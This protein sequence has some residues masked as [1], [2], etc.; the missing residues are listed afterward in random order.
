VTKDAF[1]VSRYD[2]EQNLF[3][4]DLVFKKPRGEG[5]VFRATLSPRKS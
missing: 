5:E 4:L 3:L 1:Y 2:E